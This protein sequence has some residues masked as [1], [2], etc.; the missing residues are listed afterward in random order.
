MSDKQ[1]IFCRKKINFFKTHRSYSNLNSLTMWKASIVRKYLMAVTG[2]ALVGFLITHLA[3]N[4][5]LFETTG[6][7][8]NEYALMLEK[9]GS[10]KELAEIGLFVL[11]G[12]HILLA[13]FLTAENK[14]AR[15]IKYAVW[16]SK[17]STGS[18][19]ASPSARRM[20]FTGFFILLP[21]L[22]FHVLHFAKGPGIDQGY[23]T[24]VKGENARDLYR[25]VVEE[26]HNPWIVAIYVTAM[27]AM[28][29]HLRH[30]FWSAFQSLGLLVP[31]LSKPISILALIIAVALA[32]G[33][34]AIPMWIYLKGV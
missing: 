8:F 18:A 20:I 15:P 23:S 28:G 9:L 6:K 17:Q 24:E 21:F 34:L 32:A 4:I 7:A 30:G 10:L 1:R 13:I 33:F 29:F 14:K 2:L 31:R 26:F 19:V 11:F 12:V 5:L 16:K 27:L 25:L 3:G 22:I